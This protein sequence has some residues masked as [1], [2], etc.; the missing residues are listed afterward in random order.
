M[1]NQINGNK[2]GLKIF[3]WF[4]LIYHI[5]FSA[6]IRGVVLD[7]KN[8]NTP[9]SGV[10]V[11]AGYG[12][13]RTKTDP[14]GRFS[15]DAA[16]ISGVSFPDN[17]QLKFADIRLDLRR[18]IIDLGNAL[19]IISISL[20]KLDGKR[21]FHQFIKPENTRVLLPQITHGVYLICF[22]R[23]DGRFFVWKIIDL[24]LYNTFK[25]ALPF[26]NNH[27]T[28]TSASDSIY[29][30]IFRH[31]DYYPVER[32]LLRASDSLVV[33]MD[34]DPRRY[35]FDKTKIH[36]YSFTISREDSIAMERSASDP[37]EPFFPATLTFN[38]TS[39]G[40]VG[41][42]YK[43]SEYSLTRCFDTAGNRSDYYDCRN[44]SLKI[45]FD[46]YDSTQRFYEMKRLNLHSM[47]YDDSKLREMI[48]YELF[49]EN[50]I[51]TSRTAFAKVYINNV[52]R[53]LFTVVENI[54]GRFTKSRWPDFG[55]GNL[56]KEAW[57]FRTLLTYYHAALKTNEELSNY[58]VAYRMKAFAETIKASTP[59]TFVKDI[60]SYID[61][62]Y[63][64][65]YIVVDRAIHNADGIMTWYVDTNSGWMG[66]HN[67]YFYEE[68]NPGGKIWII[69]WDLNVTL[70][71]SDPVVDDYDMPEWNEVPESC[72]PLEIWGGS[73]SMPPNCDKLTGL[74]AKTLWKEFVS[75]GEQ[76][77]SE[78]FTPEK[79]INKITKY[80]SLIDSIMVYE[81]TMTYNKWKK[82]VD[83]LKADMYPLC[84][85]FDDHIHSRDATVDTTG[86]FTTL[87]YDGGLLI[88]SVNNF[89]F[90]TIKLI[91]SWTNVD[92]SPGSSINISIDTTDPLWGQ[93]DILCSF[94]IRPVDAGKKFGEWIHTEFYFNEPT[95]LSK[96]KA[97][98]ICLKSNNSRQCRICLLSDIYDQNGVKVA[99]GWDVFIGKKN[100]TFI[101]PI[102]RIDYPQLTTAE[103][104]DLLESVLKSVKGIGINPGPRYDDF[105]K[106]L[107]IPDSG[108]V[109]IDNIIFDFYE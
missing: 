60:S 65:R 31:D 16:A 44:V 84:K 37:Q 59:E 56:Y 86:F 1:P 39:F 6:V 100:K 83:I 34:P 103:N 14:E 80:S 97:M 45:K 73:L 102:E 58:S 93:A 94:V 64:L 79:L 68:E 23:K 50:G 81:P 108:F 29:Y 41:L 8:G 47:S 99:Y 63:W 66:N 35:I 52:F 11:S 18:R 26:Y 43:G 109:R 2:K 74:T 3:C 30:L 33:T 89:E 67:Y 57:P 22:G 19:D 98:R 62:D 32:K 21:I 38:Q 88:G 78:I 61:I 25:I 70:Y 92:V 71:P 76:F 107:E 7:K 90:D 51:Y 96:L 49:R 48:S 9:I 17:R 10:L 46:K 72:D 101:L 55:N 28:A 95:D 75:F 53:G 42:R 5:S 77:I 69:P 12:L 87:H 24:N 105:G 36:T 106:L 27:T 82:A 20:Y 54:D 15:I 104:P 13:Q 85:D 91:D 4:L 40:T